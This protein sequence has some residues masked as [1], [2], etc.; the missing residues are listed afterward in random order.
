MAAIALAPKHRWLAGAALAGLFW[1]AAA[2]AEEP[3]KKIIRPPESGPPPLPRAFVAA[4]GK[5]T[6][7]VR[8]K[9]YKAGVFAD[10]TE[11]N[12]TR[13]LNDLHIKGMSDPDV[14]PAV[15]KLRQ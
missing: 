10:N 13:A 4:V 14:N 3:P 12:Q 9:V 1:L 6:G 2:P 11:E 5:Y 15:T 7:V 8:L